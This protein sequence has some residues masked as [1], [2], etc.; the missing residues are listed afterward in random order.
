MADVAVVVTTYMPPGNVGRQRARAAKRAIDS[1]WENF[2]HRTATIAIIIADDGSDGA[3]YAEMLRSLSYNVGIKQVVQTP[4][5]GTG[6][7]LNAGLRYVFDNDLADVV[8][9]GADDWEL[10]EPLDLAPSLALLREEYADV[11]RLGPTHPN[12]TA[13]VMRTAVPSAEWCLQY[14]WYG[15]GYVFGHRPALHHRRMYEQHGYYIENASAIEVEREYNERLSKAAFP[16]PIWHA[17][18]CTLAGP[19]RHIDTVE[20]GEDTPATL[21]ER[22]GG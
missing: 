15:G 11:V 9:Y 5:L 10:T 18:N 22:Y 4:R 20:L 17:P 8:F 21:T 16:P 14:A 1:W 3:N 13:G 7:A 19:F 12:L 6:G 2:E